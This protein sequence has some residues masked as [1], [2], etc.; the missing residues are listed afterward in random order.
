VHTMANKGHFQ[1]GKSG[2]DAAKF[3]P[4]QSG[5]PKGKPTG[6]TLHTLLNE[7]LEKATP[8]EIRDTKFVKEFLFQGKGGKKKVTNAEALAARL[9]ARAL[10]N[11]D[12]K[13]IKEI[14][15]RVGG[16]TNAAGDLNITVHVN[17]EQ[18]AEIIQNELDKLGE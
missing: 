3:K 7:L 1:K 16:T 14:F 4:G 15:D 6:K 18:R 9:I 5:N 17:N 2:N 11:N 8:Q 12:M 13:A 10:V